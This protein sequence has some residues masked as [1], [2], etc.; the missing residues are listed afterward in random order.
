MSGA[1]EAGRSGSGSQVL[2]QMCAAGQD[3]GCRGVLGGGGARLRASGGSQR[4]RLL[5]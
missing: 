2:S 5:N 1:A 3:P 4:E